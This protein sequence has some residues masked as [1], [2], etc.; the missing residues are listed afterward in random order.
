MKSYE[1]LAKEAFEA[2]VAETER[3]GGFKGIYAKPTWAE[4]HPAFKQGWVAAAKHLWT[5]F[6]TTH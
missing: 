5:Q 3:Q 4:I 6:S 1:Q 2:H